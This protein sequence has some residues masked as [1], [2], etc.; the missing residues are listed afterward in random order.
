[1]LPTGLQLKKFVSPKKVAFQLEKLNLQDQLATFHKI[2]GKEFE[3]K[4]SRSKS[5]SL[6]T[7]RVKKNKTKKNGKE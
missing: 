2:L 3:T 5:S 1:M 4:K 6:K 7:N